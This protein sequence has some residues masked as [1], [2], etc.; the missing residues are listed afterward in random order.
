MTT[1]NR[2][3]LGQLIGT[4]A[5]HPN[6]N[7]I[8][9][10]DC[11]YETELII[12]R[13]SGNEDRI[14]IT[15]PEKLMTS[16][17]KAGDKVA[18]QGEYRS[19][20]KPGQLHSKL[21]LHFLV[22]E[23]LPLESVNPNQ[24]N[25]LELTGFVCKKPVYRVTPFNREICDVLLAVNRPRKGDRGFTKSDYIPCIMWGKNARLMRDTLVGSKLTLTGRIQSREYL[26]RLE[27]GSE[28]TRVAYEVSCNTISLES[29]SDAAKVRVP[30]A[31]EELG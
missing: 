9:E 16:E 7:F 1:E 19:Y 24:C 26:K 14:P 11:F 13:L 22:Q 21:V 31:E 10:N 17:L 8:V 6:K 23:F 27:D 18:L 2:T 5:K 12:P 25:M 20:N 28:Q 29:D 3:N 4:I 15:I 30:E